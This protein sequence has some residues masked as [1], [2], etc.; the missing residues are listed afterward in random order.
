M[1]TTDPHTTV[2]TITCDGC[3]TQTTDPE[4]CPHGLELCPECVETWACQRCSGE[5]RFEARAGL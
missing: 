5:A 3:Q 4:T 2:E 1:T